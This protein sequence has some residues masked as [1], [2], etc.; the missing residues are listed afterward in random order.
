MPTRRQ[1]KGAVATT[2]ELP[3]FIPPMLAKPG[4]PFDDPA[5][6]AIENSE[7]VPCDMLIFSI[8]FDDPFQHGSN[9]GAGFG[10]QFVQVVKGDLM[11]TRQGKSAE[12]GRVV[13]QQPHQHPSGGRISLEKG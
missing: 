2:Q 7:Q 10:F 5:Y 9:G 12:L 3:R 13:L 4:E 11:Q 6:F 1:S 8:L